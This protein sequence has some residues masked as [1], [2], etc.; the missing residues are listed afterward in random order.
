MRARWVVPS[1]VLFVLPLVACSPSKTA[2]GG[3]STRPVDV[4]AAKTA[5]KAVIDRFP[6]S[7]MKKDTTAV[8]EIFAHD[9]EMVV[10]GTDS[11]EH[12]VGYDAVAAGMNSE[13]AAFANTKIDVRDQKIE[14][15]PAGD[16]AW[17]SEIMDWDFDMGGQH[18]HA[19]D[20][21]ATGILVNRDGSWR[22]E[23]FHGSLPAGGTS[24]PQ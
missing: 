15:D 1:A 8:G 16:V 5:V 6:E 17:F 2:G 11:T 19:H 7:F 10:F 13:I 3:G 21:R 4:E 24:P 9:P 18:V 20:L 23:Q 14:M 22:M 12:W